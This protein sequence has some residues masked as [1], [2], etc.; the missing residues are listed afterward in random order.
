MLEK[1]PLVRPIPLLVLVAVGSAL[2]ALSLPALFSP[3]PP[4]P[5]QPGGRGSQ[6]TA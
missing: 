4:G 2:V 6:A 3:P 1:Q 5:L